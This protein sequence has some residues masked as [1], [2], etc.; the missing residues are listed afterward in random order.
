MTDAPKSRIERRR[1][2]DLEAGDKK[3]FDGVERALDS[4]ADAASQGKQ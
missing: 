3:L 4:R 2:T 1:E